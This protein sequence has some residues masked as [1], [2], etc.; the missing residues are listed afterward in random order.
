MTTTSE[1]G[2][3]LVTAVI[4]VAV[5]SFLA[6]EMLESSRASLALVQARSDQAQLAAAADSAI[7]IAIHGLGLSDP[8]KRITPDGVAHAYYF[9]GVNLS[10]TVEDEK[11]KVVIN[12]AKPDVERKLLAAAGVTGARLDV[13]VDSLEDWKDY[14]DAARP[15]GAETAYY[16]PLGYPPRNDDIRRLDELAL[17]RGMNGVLLARIAPAITLFAYGYGGFDKDVANPLALAAMSNGDDSFDLQDRLQSMAGEH[18]ALAIKNDQSTMGEIYSI[19]VNASSPDGARMSR[20]E[21]VEFTGDPAD[22]YW[23]RYVQ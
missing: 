10:V 17:I 15:N 1:A 6:L 5:F 4:G 19:S 23:V 13:L 18:T 8:D 21:V 11:G 16:A 20:M 7:A 12:Q 14:D 22:P 2:S 9:G 3:A